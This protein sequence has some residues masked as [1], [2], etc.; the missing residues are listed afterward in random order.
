MTPLPLHPRD[1]AAG[2]RGSQPPHR[3]DPLAGR[4]DSRRLDPGRPLAKV[5][6]L[7][8]T[9]IITF[10]KI[11]SLL[12]DP[13]AHGGRPE[14]AFHVVAPSL[15]GH[16]FSDKPTETGWGIPRI[17]NAWI[18]LMRRL[19]YT[20]WVAQ[21]EDWGS[22]VTTAIGASLAALNIKFFLPYKGKTA[23]PIY[24]DFGDGKRAFFWLKQG[25]PD[26]EAP[27]WAFMAETDAKVEELY[28][29]SVAAG[30]KG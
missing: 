27:H 16:G 28:E 8:I 4:G 14:D 21:G 5:K 12:T 26:P 10:M 11:I 25:K 2:P 23:N 1:P 22:V 24:R 18:T 29:A 9:G 13:T 15:P 3:S 7:P 20:R 17:A 30:A 6:A 19:G